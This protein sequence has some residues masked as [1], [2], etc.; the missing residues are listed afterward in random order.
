MN[1]L[2]NTSISFS[3]V[4]ESNLISLFTYGDDKFDDKR[5]GKH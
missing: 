2:E 3:V 1:D 5:I 4:S